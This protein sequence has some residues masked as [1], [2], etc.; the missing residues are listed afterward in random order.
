MAGR[1]PRESEATIE[2]Y[3]R[4]RDELVSMQ[5]VRAQLFVFKVTGLGAIYY[6]AASAAST[7][8]Q[9][10]AEGIVAV[11]LAPLLAAMLDFVIE[12]HS[13]AIKEIGHYIRT[14]I[15]PTLFDGERSERIPAPF[16]PYEMYLA[17]PHG[18]VPLRRGLATKLVTV[19]ALIVSAITLSSLKPFGEPLYLTGTWFW[20][21]LMLAVV[22]LTVV[23]VWHRAPIDWLRVRGRGDEIVLVTGRYRSVCDRCRKVINPGR[24][25][26]RGSLFDALVHGGHP[27]RSPLQLLRAAG[28][29][30]RRCLSHGSHETLNLWRRLRE[31]S[32]PRGP[33]VL[34]TLMVR[35]FR[36]TWRRMR[37]IMR[38]FAAK[39]AAPVVWELIGPRRNL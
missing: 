2:V 34:T 14:Q 35:Q 20:L 4:L 8:E 22:L 15:E 27:R 30:M 18:R 33:R 3:A 28:A 37:A 10:S 23:F 9:R 36:S 6:L 7:S 17:T 32:A 21:W 26:Q 29:L 38:R 13:L 25:Y 1:G 24:D 31:E 39:T 5:T 12:G 11:T 16:V 19:L